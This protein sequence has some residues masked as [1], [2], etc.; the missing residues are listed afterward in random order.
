MIRDAMRDAARDALR[1]PFGATPGAFPASLPG[2]VLFRMD[3]TSLPASGPV[4][5]IT[6]LSGRGNDITATVDWMLGT[7]TR[8]RATLKG[9][10]TQWGQVDYATGPYAQP[11]IRFVA[12][13]HASGSVSDPEYLVDGGSDGERSAVLFPSTAGDYAVFAG[14]TTRYTGESYD[15]AEHY[16]ITLM[17]GSTS[18]MWLD[19]VLI[20]QGEDPGSDAL[21]GIT[22]MN[23]FAPLAGTDL[24]NGEIMAV[25]DVVPDD[26]AQCMALLDEYADYNFS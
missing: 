13:K 19:G 21:S 3:H 20:W 18:E 6:D 10:G 12:F 26:V 15:A 4:S 16:L 23:R 2:T 7:D 1:S 25:A 9:T 5:L 24:F 11:Y 8:G 17:R 14:G 22:L